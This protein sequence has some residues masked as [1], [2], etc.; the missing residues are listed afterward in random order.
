MRQRSVVI[1]GCW[2]LVFG[3]FSH[4]TTARMMRTNEAARTVLVLLRLPCVAADVYVLKRAGR[5]LSL[6]TSMLALSLV[7]VALSAVIVFGG[8]DK[9]AAALVVSGL[10]VFDLSAITV[11]AF[12]AE[13]YPTVLRGTALG[14]CYMSGRLGAFV[15]PFVDEMRSPPLRG[16]AYAASAAMLLLLSAMAFA[17]PETRQLPP[18]NTVQGMMAMEDKWLLYSPLRVAR[19]GGKRRRSRTPSQERAQ[20]RSRTPSSVRQ[21]S[22]YKPATF[23]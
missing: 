1:L 4:L 21:L 8:N 15:A 22:G 9:L 23:R 5:R 19:S 17:L 11:F 6:A 2:F 20:S 10:L 14:C 7:H 16:A 18:S 3:T 13:L 12:S